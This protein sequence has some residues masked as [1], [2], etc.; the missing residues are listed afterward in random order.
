MTDKRWALF[1]VIAAGAACSHGRG[2]RSRAEKQPTLDLTRD[3][4]WPAY[5]LKQRVWREAAQG[6]DMDLAR[7][8]H[9]E[10]MA[11][12]LS[13]LDHGGNLGRTALAAIGWS[14][15]HFASRGALCSR[16][17]LCE[18]RS[19]ERLLEAVHGS[20]YSA[21]RSVESVDSEADQACSQALVAVA[22][23]PGLSASA[24]DLVASAGLALRSSAEPAP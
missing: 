14:D 10:P 20:L 13:A 9:Q 3:S 5:F 1:V 22:Q 2:P 19:L 15:E 4:A 23:R 7:L 6:D 24:Q 18:G 21:D 12:L 8:A 11:E 16:L 17:A